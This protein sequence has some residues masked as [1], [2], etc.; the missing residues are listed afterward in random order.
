MISRRVITTTALI[1]TFFF[2]GCSLV[3]SAKPDSLETTMQTSRPKLERIV[4]DTSRTEAYNPTKD[5]LL[6]TAKTTYEDATVAYNSGDDEKAKFLFDE[7]L[8]LFLESNISADEYTQLPHL[9]DAMETISNLRFEN[10]DLNGNENS[11]DITEENIASLRDSTGFNLSNLSEP[12]LKEIAKYEQKFTNDS[13]LR[14][15]FIK[16][17]EESGL[18]DEFDKKLIEKNGFPEYYTG[19]PKIESGQDPEAVS[20]ANAFSRW[21][22]THAT[23][24]KYG[25]DYYGIWFDDKYDPIF[26]AHAAM[27]YLKDLNEMF[28]NDPL[29]AIAG[30]NRGENG[31]LNSMKNSKSKNFDEVFLASVKKEDS[32]VPM[33][34]LKHIPQILAISDLS[35][36]RGKKGFKITSKK[37]GFILQCLFDGK[38]D[39]IIVDQETDLEVIA[40]TIGIT[41]RVLKQYNPRVK[42]WMTP[43]NEMYE[44][45]GEEYAF[46]M[47]VPKGLGEVYLEKIV[48]VKERR[49]TKR[50]KI[51]RVKKGENV[52]SISKQYGVPENW[53]V[54]ANK[55]KD[56]NMISEGQRLVIP[57]Y[58]NAKIIPISN[59]KLE[60]T[61]KD[62]SRFVEIQ[63]KVQR[64]NTLDGISNKFNKEY[65][66]TNTSGEITTKNLRDWNAIKRGQERNIR[67]GQTLDVWIS[68][69]NYKK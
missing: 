37:P 46:E 9:Y 32:S 11:I 21:Q 5:E 56:R 29:M 44:Q 10:F 36:N 38:F 39:T 18:Y 16:T 49:I 45:R 52:G 65:N 69:E 7:S 12:L 47:R 34:T 62:T 60:P 51:H 20:L 68:K 57:A 24:K 54:T 33:E 35:N 64:G 1:G 27:R 48:N 28:A 17:E 15:W 25:L 59:V 61:E 66:L 31:M 42:Q 43:P 23:G 55:I 50:D 14:K 22:F 58:A 8:K 6:L 30:Y 3:T 19:I 4:S 26:S 13:K 40:N 53:I 67:V 2:A 41:E 63:Y